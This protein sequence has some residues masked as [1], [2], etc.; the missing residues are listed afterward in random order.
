MNEM[1][2]M[3]TNGRSTTPIKTFSFGGQSIEFN[4]PLGTVGF[5]LSGGLD[6][7][8]LLAFACEYIDQYDLMDSITIQPFHGLENLRPN[9]VI[10]VENI[11]EIIQK[12]YPSVKINDLIVYPVYSE[13]VY[14]EKK[15]GPD[16]QGKVPQMNAFYNQYCKDNDISCIVMAMNCLPEQYI[17][18]EWGCKYYSKDRMRRDRAEIVLFENFCYYQPM[19]NVDKRLTAAMFKYCQ[20]P[21]SIVDMNT[22]CTGFPDETDYYQKPCGKCYHCME[23][24]WAFGKL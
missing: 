23:K 6:S 21:D 22:S 11:L 3:T 12:K 2:N 1:T 5:T 19:V 17:L 15:Q 13:I 9:T 18:D 4:L 7:T 16:E 24:K 8:T 10:D 20:L 14:S